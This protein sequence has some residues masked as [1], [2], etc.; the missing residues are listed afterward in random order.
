MPLFTIDETRCKR[1]GLCAADCPAGC[2]VF[3]K[4]GLPEPH[5]KKQA[6]WTAATAWPSARPTPSG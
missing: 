4:G 2:I 6:Y 1:D 3:E 5:E